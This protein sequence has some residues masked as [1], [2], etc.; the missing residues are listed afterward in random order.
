M[1]TRNNAANE[2]RRLDDIKENVKGLVERGQER[3]NAIKG[4]AADLQHRAK[5]RGGAALD[6]TT[7]LIKEHPIAAVSVAFGI[8]YLLMRLVRR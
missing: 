1:N 5:Q 6:R 4:K 7:S 2:H 3:V 8:G